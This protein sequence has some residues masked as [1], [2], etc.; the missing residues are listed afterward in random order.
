MK[1][2]I[3]AATLLV[4]SISSSAVAQNPFLT[5]GNLRSACK[6]YVTGDPEASYVEKGICLGWVIS[7][8]SWR[9]AACFY[10]RKESDPGWFAFEAA[11][12]VIE[13]SR[14]ALVQA[15]LNWADANP[16]V[17]SEPHLVISRQK[18]F[19][20]QFPCIP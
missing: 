6:A 13:P 10:V 12:N 14:D 2:G 5:V 20:S 18:D 15:F 8:S 19:W 17:W 1:I 3:I 11:R 16:H 7:E 4:F 9:S